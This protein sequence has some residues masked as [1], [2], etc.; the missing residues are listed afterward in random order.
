M[1]QITW[2]FSF[3]PP[4]FWNILFFA[5]IGAVIA[6]WILKFIPFISTY[7]LPIQ[8]A[9]IL[10][11]MTSIWFLGAASNEEKWQAEINK[12]KEQI[13]QLEK[14]SDELNEQLR[15]S[16]AETEKIRQEKAKSVIKYLDKFVTKEILKEVEGPE[17][18]R[19]EEV[20][21]IVERCPIPKELID[22]HNAGARGDG[23]KK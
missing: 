12:A 15:L 16:Q 11:I 2:M 1:W 8:V 13:G 3:I 5:G 19:I 14:K 21:K 22:A 7:R 6:A 4:W 20:I 23:M 18:V 10:S 9:G 17:R